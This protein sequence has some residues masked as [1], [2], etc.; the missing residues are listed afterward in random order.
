MNPT[1]QH[2]TAVEKRRL[3]RQVRQSAQGL[4]DIDQVESSAK[5]LAGLRQRYG[6]SGDD[7]VAVV[8]LKHLVEHSC[9]HLYR[10]VGELVDQQIKSTGSWT[11]QRQLRLS[12]LAMYRRFKNT[13]AETVCLDKLGE[14]NLRR[15]DQVET[16]L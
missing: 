3:R 9:V 10:Q 4:L 7:G 16:K 12:E 15:Y 1:H 8:F 2:P 13:K 14:L 5:I 6:N 11:N